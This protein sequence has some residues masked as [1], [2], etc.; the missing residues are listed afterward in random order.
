MNKIKVIIISFIVA[1]ISFV[2]V[3][4]TDTSYTYYGAQKVYR[5]YLNGE[6]IGLI[7][8][9]EKLNKYINNEQTKLKEKY[10]RTYGNNYFCYPLNNNLENVFKEC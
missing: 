10:I 6:S 5:V 1:I 4:I 3:V 2:F 8:N 7:K 9:P